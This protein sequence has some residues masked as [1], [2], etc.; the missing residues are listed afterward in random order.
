MPVVRRTRT[1]SKPRRLLLQVLLL[2]LIVTIAL[3]FFIQ[4]SF[5]SVSTV[6]IRNNKFLSS[7]EIKQLADIPMGINIFKV[8]DAKVKQNIALHPMVKDVKLRRQLPDTLI[9]SIEERQPVV[10]VPSET[11]FIELDE[12]GVL[13]QRISTI[14]G[15][16]LPI[17]T[18]VKINTDISPGQVVV[19]ENLAKT[20][21]FISKIP[22]DKR[23][24]LMEI[25]LKG[26]EYIVY[27]PQGIQVRFGSPEKVEQKIAILEE[28]IK[29]G[30]L[31]DKIIE[32]IDLTTVAT[33][34]IKYRD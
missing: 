27:T 28:I 14:S 11:G 16:S 29:S 24:L 1:I 2:C 21:E 6:E 26:F 8:E 5:F 13:L 31:E 34:V 23:A 18:G 12:S 30:Q 22:E 3:Y 15:V 7:G 9:I 25:E 19:N 4:S 32:Y 10:L 20:L 33:P 17:L